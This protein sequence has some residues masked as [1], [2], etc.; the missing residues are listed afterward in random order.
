MGCP[1][2]YGQATDVQLRDGRRFVV[3]NIAWGQ[4]MGDPEFHITTNISPAPSLAADAEPLQSALDPFISGTFFAN[5]RPTAALIDYRIG[6]LFEVLQA[7]I[8]SH[9]MIAPGIK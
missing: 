3:I 6:E 1:V 4:D 8:D 2:A 7:S 5:N 9:D